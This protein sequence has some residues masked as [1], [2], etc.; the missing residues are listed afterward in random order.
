MDWAIC[1]LTILFTHLKLILK[2]LELFGCIMYNRFVVTLRAMTQ[3]VATVR[4]RIS[5]SDVR[6]MKPDD[7]VTVL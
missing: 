1:L 2:T 6:F 5:A 3:E 4:Q 7:G